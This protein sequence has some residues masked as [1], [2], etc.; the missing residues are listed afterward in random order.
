[1]PV[2]EPRRALRVTL[3]GPSFGIYGGVQAVMLAIARSLTDEGVQVRV[4]FKLVNGTSLV[5]S[6]RDV[7]ER[8]GLDCTV[9][10]KPTA[11]SFLRALGWADV[12]HVHTPSPDICALA[13]L[14]Q[15]PVAVTVHNHKPDGDNNRL[16][17]SRAA[18]YLSQRIWFTSA[19]V[20]QTWG[21][22][23]KPPRVEKAPT[24]ADLPTGSVPPAARRGFVS[25]A[26][27]IPNKGLDDLIRAYALAHIDHADQPLTIVGD[28]PLKPSLSD[29]AAANGVADHVS[30]PG[31]VDASTRDALI[32]NSR[33]LV[34]PAKTKEDLGLTPIEAR[35]VGVPCIVTRDG[36]LP[37]AG[38]REAL[39][40]EPGDVS[41]LAR[42][43]ETASNLGAEE[44]AARSE[45]TRWELIEYL[46][47]L[48]WFGERYRDMAR[49]KHVSHG[50]KDA[51]VTG[52]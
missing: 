34:A 31:F 3:A 50:R 24:V 22:R 51:N 45:R 46:R 37:E 10:T 17:K 43:L 27:L 38:G 19:F 13:R 11:S 4:C 28:G 7:L 21:M 26:R 16:W 1:M 6:F 8:S 35:H 41:G 52:V 49:A 32:R 47:P 44:Y 42:S 14:M 30:L 29:L 36:G 2:V 9:T 5:P 25:I 12:V 15:R 39:L 18:L 48:S 20:G 40:C 33:W 23:E